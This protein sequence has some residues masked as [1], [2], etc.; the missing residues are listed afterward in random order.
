MSAEIRIARDALK[1][2]CLAVMPCALVAMLVR[3]FPAALSVFAAFGIV[4]ANAGL[5]AVVSAGAGKISP[6]TPAL[7]AL[8]SFALRMMGVVAA[9]VALSSVRGIDQTVF[10]VAFALAVVGVLVV[11]SHRWAH[12]PWIAM[13]FLE[14]KP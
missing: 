6:T 3:G 5:A 9:L 7:M 1:W 11:E 10:A 14:E 8:P 4:L 12:T 13:T 2:G